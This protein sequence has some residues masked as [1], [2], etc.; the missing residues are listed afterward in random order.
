VDKA[1]LFPTSRVI[2][3]LKP[4]RINKRTVGPRDLILTEAA[5]QVEGAAIVIR[6]G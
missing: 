1:D 4:G 6:T 3:A 5:V 2:F